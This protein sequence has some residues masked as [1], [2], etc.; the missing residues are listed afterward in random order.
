MHLLERQQPLAALEALLTNL[1][2]SGGHLALI[3][4]QA[5]I[6]KTSLVQLFLDQRVPRRNW[7]LG[8][9]EALA[10]P[11]PLG[12]L[13]EIADQVGGALGSVFRMTASPE[14]LEVVKQ[15]ATARQIVAVV[16]DVHWADQASLDLLT[17]VG[18]RVARLGKLIILTLRDDELSIDHP[19]RKVLGSFATS[20]D[21]SHIRLSP[22]SLSSVQTLAANTG[23]DTELLHQRTGGNPFF[24]TQVLATG[25]ALDVPYAVRDVIT[26]RLGRLRDDDR[27]FVQ[28]ASVLGRADRTVLKGVFPD[29]DKRLDA[30]IAVG[31]MRS[32][33]GG[34][35]FFH[36][37]AREAVIG[38]IAEHQ[39]SA[40][41]KEVLVALIRAGSTDVA[42]LAAH[43]EQAGD[44]EAIVQ[45]AP[46][47]AR[48][49][50]AAGAQ[51]EAVRHF[52]SAL[53]HVEEPHERAMLLSELG[54][55][56]VVLD[57]NREAI[58]NFEEAGR[59]WQALG[60]L[61]RQAT[62]LIA[63]ATPLF[64]VGRNVESAA[65]DDRA[66]AILE[67]LGAGVELAAALRSRAQL[68]MLERNK[69]E[70]LHFGR[71]AIRMAEQLGDTAILAA[72]NQTVAITLLVADDLDGQ[73]YLDRATQLARE[74]GLDKLLSIGL[75]NAGSS[76]GEQYRFEEA[77]RYLGHAIA[78]A[79]ERDFD[80][81]RHYDEA[82]LALV[83]LFTGR[84]GAAEETA[85]ALL[86]TAEIS[87]IARI[88]AL[89]AIGRSRARR[90]L[91]VGGVLDEAL[92]LANP[93]GTLQ[94]I[95][96]VRLARAEAAW[97]A[98]DVNRTREEADAT[99]SLAIGHRHQW[100][101][102]EVAYW[103]NEAGSAAILQPWFAPPYFA[104]LSG[105]WRDAAELWSER[106]CP[107]ERARALA[108]GDDAAKLAALDIFE[109]LG[110]R[111]AADMLRQQMRHSGADYVPR[112]PRPATRQHAFGLTTRQQE[113]ADLITEG[114][115]NSAISKRLRISG[116][117]VEHHVSVILAKLAVK[118]RTDA[119]ARLSETTPISDR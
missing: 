118:T 8:S 49:A 39:L 12:P 103:Q 74:N 44:A 70:A 73:K 84:F 17:F 40:L 117:T 86:K 22:L 18:R 80:A 6:G 29:V 72:A 81:H 63:L 116:K 14:P 94:R 2:K 105:R 33:G 51:R 100:H 26:E 15:L 69:I 45:F 119:V 24:V 92:E 64:S 38:T 79:G 113:I 58:A 65:V 93:T 5:G 13:R 106:N 77:E 87:T 114:L 99:Q 102:A 20:R 1:P 66:I 10:T 46:Q 19:L 16:E 98:G 9:C 101:A 47:A 37:L 97:L 89:V 7:V 57:R 21:V 60:D 67:P 95:A 54:D 56:L 61:R 59:L 108:D 4:G 110:T 11:E 3:S 28:L 88:M 104:Q 75:M 41:H 55:A 112:G 34:A 62:T 91:H 109:A 90:G 83:Q 42:R 35:V 111:P 36:D 32:D 53:K 52:T 50:T 31:L 96:P 78:F 27:R 85:T 30:A 23:I 43:A 48:Q 68:H 76:F 82:W 71:R 115:T 107:Y 25:N